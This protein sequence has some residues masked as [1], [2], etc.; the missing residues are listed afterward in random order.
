MQNWRRTGGGSLGVTGVG[1]GILGIN[2]ILFLAMSCLSIQISAQF[3][4][5]RKLCRPQLLV[6]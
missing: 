3:S 4:A 1:I 2:E 6:K 5:I